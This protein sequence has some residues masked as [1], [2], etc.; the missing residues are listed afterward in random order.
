MTQAAETPKEYDVVAQ[1]ENAGDVKDIGI[2][3]ALEDLAEAERLAG[4]LRP[5]ILG[6][7]VIATPVMENDIVMTFMLDGVITNCVIHKDVRLEA[8]PAVLAAMVP[9]VAG[10]VVGVAIEDVTD[11]DYEE[12]D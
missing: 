1:I 9:Y 5:K 8:V 10:K 3:L 4:E 7:A 11:W 12:E 2:Y 6:A